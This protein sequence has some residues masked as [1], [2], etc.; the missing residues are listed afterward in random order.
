VLLVA[1]LVGILVA[2]TPTGREL[3]RGSDDL[4]LRLLAPDRQSEDVIVF[5][6]DDA[7]LATLQAAFGAWP[8]KRDVYAL[9]IETLREAGARAIAIDLLFA[10]SGP[11]DA[12]LARA[13][14]RPG[15]PVV[16]AAAGLQH[17]SDQTVPLQALAGSALLPAAAEPPAQIWPA[18]T[19]PVASVWQDVAAPRFGVITTPLDD[20]GLLRSLPAWHQDARARLP[21]L[22]LAVHQALEPGA[23]PL[24]LDDAGGYRLVMPGP[25]HW[26]RV[27]PFSDLARVALGQRD[28]GALREAVA[29]RVV[30]IGSSA[31]LADTVMTTQGQASGTTVLAQMYSALA[32]NQG[33]RPHDLR[34]DLALLM[35][36]LLPSAWAVA[37]GR[38]KPAREATSAAVAVVAL[39]A[40]SLAV[41]LGG[42]QPAAWLPPLAAL[43]TG[44]AM[45]LWMFQRGQSA[46]RLRLA[47][48]LEVLEATAKAKAAFL[49]NVSH[50]IRTPLNALLGVSELLAT[51]PLNA[52]QRLHVQLFREA[53]QTLHALINDLLDLSKVEA[54]RLEIHPAPFDLHQALGQIVRL[55]QVRAEDKGISLALD[56][57]PELPVHVVGDA[58]RLEQA[59]LNLVGNAIKFT[60]RGEV[61]LWARPDPEEPRL[62]RFDVQDTGIGIAASKLETVFEPFA[63]ADG[64]VTRIYGGTG[65]GLSITRSL[66][67]LMG[68][69][70]QVKSTPGVG[71]TFTLRL[72]LPVA[73]PAAAATDT[74]PPAPAP[75]PAEAPRLPEWAHAGEPLAV[76]LAEDNEVNA[77]IF[78]A[79]LQ[80]QPLALH[81]AANG[82]AALDLLERQDFSL[83]F[84]DVQ[85]PGMDG[86]TV[87]RE[88]R[89]LE[90]RQQRARTPVVALTAN[91]FPSDVQASLDAG[92]DRHLP[93]PFT[94]D[95]LVATIAQL[96]RPRSAVPAR[97]ESAHEPDEV[98]AVLDEAA[99][100]R[101]AG[102]DAALHARLREHALVF[103]TDWA[104]HFDQAL[105]DGQPDRAHR[106]AHDLRSI[107]GNVGAN[108]LADCAAA[109]ERSLWKAEPG[110]APDEAARARTLAALHPVI[111]ALSAAPAAGS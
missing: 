70:V 38:V 60:P 89:R 55:M 92:C 53:G 25:Q 77:Y 61:W 80:D 11:A 8:Y 99:A 52:Q 65:L 57:A 67:A 37:R 59:L 64:S 69:T 22:P 7:S 12:A 27:L 32:R 31:L 28:T 1:A 29:G 107:A 103:M 68:G 98:R 39:A 4:Q 71:S 35:L 111:A 15:A 63:Q 106:L 95:M 79:M 104:V 3:G 76:L 47:R 30:F 50:E 84:I 49:A 34:L 85:M 16:L 94:R 108:T 109:L 42:R 33:V 75:A 105:R 54:G 73:E 44:L 91:A 2:V 78:R 81:H 72:P 62:L 24:R 58:L 23:A 102:G 19:L 110:Q 6:I 86:L 100:A 51:T 17:G 18:L 88:L 36:A 9:A 13:V 101:R 87:T 93:K 56:I 46:A 43:G 74:G 20:D 40:L 90:A 21:A 14:A 26:P 45:A 83:A 41:L 10:D 5:D 48:E 82:P 96:A 66:A 97:A